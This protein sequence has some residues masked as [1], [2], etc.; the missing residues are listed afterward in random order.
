MPGAA[1][2]AGA[3]VTEA[4]ASCGKSLSPD[5]IAVTKKLVN[6]GATQFLCVNCLAAYFEVTPRDIL[7][8]IAYFRQTGCTLF[9]Q[10]GG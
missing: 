8:R 6:R 1:G 9:S 4:C 2:E 5:E 7:E 10:K 3:A